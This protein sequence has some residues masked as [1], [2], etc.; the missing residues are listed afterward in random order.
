VLTFALAGELEPVA[1]GG[2]VSDRLRRD[3]VIGL[4]DVDCPGGSKQQDNEEMLPEIFLL[5]R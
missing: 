3:G 2:R 1:V 5:T 4:A